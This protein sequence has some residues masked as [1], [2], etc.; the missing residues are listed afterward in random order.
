MKKLRTLL[1]AFTALT[2]LAATAQMRPRTPAPWTLGVRMGAG[3]GHRT[4]TTT[5]LN[6]VTQFVYTL[7]EQRETPRFTHSTTITFAHMM[8]K[9]IGFEGG[10]G[11][12]RMG[13][14]YT[15]P[16]DQLVLGDVIDPRS[17]FIYV[18]DGKI[19]T[20]VTFHDIY[21]YLE[22]PLALTFTFGKGK[23][24]WVSAAGIAPAF[25]L[26]ARGATQYDYSD[27]TDERTRYEQT[28]DYNTFNWFSFFSTGLSLKRN[29]RVEFRLQPTGRYGLLPIVDGPITANVWNVTL[30]L[31]VRIRL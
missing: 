1:V 3:M 11:Y 24:K 21:H 31:G 5:D 25:M 13:W 15:L 18:T 29:D 23:L 16:Y 10:I 28:T 19:P 20:E 14:K 22:I 17:G 9:Y 7:R 27:G 12:T 8:G 6:P 26:T 4:L 2:T 30:D